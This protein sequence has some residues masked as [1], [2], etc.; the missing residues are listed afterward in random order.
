MTSLPEQFSAARLT[1]LDNGFNLMRS[2][3]EQALDRTSRVFSLQLD[4][5]RAAVEQSSNAMRQ[6]LAA[7][8]PRDLLAIGSQSQQSLR[9]MFDFGR[10]LFSLAAGVN[11]PVLRNYSAAPPVLDAPP[12]QQESAEPAGAPAASAADVA[13]EA[14]ERTGS[15][16]ASVA[17]ASAAAAASSAASAQS[18]A[19]AGFA[20]P[21]E[22]EGAPAIDVVTSDIEPAASLKPIA[23][24]TSEALDL[25]VTPPH[26]VAASVPVEVAVEIELPKVEPVTA[27]PPA[28]A[29]TTGPV[30]TRGTKGR[31]KQR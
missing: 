16:S 6:L 2:F 20:L 26:P 11:M 9:T 17:A 5:S 25:S 3:S 1:Q 27:P 8:D 29:A 4:A 22:S 15:D 14:F 24:A 28:Q 21:T 23:E 31:K 13:P 7:R 18:P 12:A 10:E 19:A 30:D